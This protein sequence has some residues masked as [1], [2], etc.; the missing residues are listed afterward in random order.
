MS[1]HIDTIAAVSTPPGKGGVAII[2]LSGDDTYDI[3]AK[4][5]RPISGKDIAAYPNRTQI[6]GYITDGDE[7]IDDGML[8][9]FK[10]PHSYTGED[11]AEISCH[12]GVLV[13][14]Q[15]LEAVLS[16]G[17]RYAE[18]GEFTRRAFVNGKLTLTEAEAIGALLEAKSVEQIKLSSGSS[19]AKLNEKIDSIRGEITGLLSSM[20]ARIDYPEEDLGDF[21]DSELHAA[22][23][24][25]GD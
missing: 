15:V 8:T 10:A 3:V 23:T 22:L 7:A 19:R 1:T 21:T 16:A 14:R 17:A 5:F 24:K 4:V 6:Y 18:G 9:F 12:G 20:Y 13:T 2:R 11:V 25:I